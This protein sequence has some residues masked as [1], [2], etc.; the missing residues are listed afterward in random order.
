MSMFKHS[1]V[2]ASL[3][4]GAM[5]LFCSPTAAAAP[6]APALA[7]AVEKQGIGQAA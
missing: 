6:L 2:A 5:V 1:F 7:A 3:L 4:G